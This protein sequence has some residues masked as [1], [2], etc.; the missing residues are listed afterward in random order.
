MKE[1]KL[2]ENKKII[3]FARLKEDQIKKEIEEKIKLNKAPLKQK[4]QYQNLDKITTNQHGKIIFKKKFN[5][6]NY[7]WKVVEN[8]VGFNLNDETQTQN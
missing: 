3:E 6:E 7:P 1:K 5:I 2:S 8:I 4:Y